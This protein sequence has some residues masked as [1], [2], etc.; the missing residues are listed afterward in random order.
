MISSQEVLIS[1]K[2]AKNEGSTIMCVSNSCAFI[3]LPIYLNAK[4]PFRS[5]TLSIR[6]A[7]H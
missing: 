1:D 6:N 4:G 5:K 2:L 7:E 3:L